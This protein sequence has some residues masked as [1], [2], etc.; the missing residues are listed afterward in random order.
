[1]AALNEEEV[2]EEE[3]NL[4]RELNAHVFDQLG[5]GAD[6][7]EEVTNPSQKEASGGHAEDSTVVEDTSAQSFLPAIQYLIAEE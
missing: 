6:L 2:V 1:M 7:T 3:D 4:D 5:A